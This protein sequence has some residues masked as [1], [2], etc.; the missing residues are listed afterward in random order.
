LRAPG[1]SSAREGGQ[2]SERRSAEPRVIAA[3][4]RGRGGGY[5]KRQGL[6]GSGNQGS[7]ALYLSVE[8][9]GTS[10]APVPRWSR[11]RG[12][13]VQRT[14][15]GRGAEL[16]SDEGASGRNQADGI[17]PQWCFALFPG[18]AR[19]IATGGVGWEDRRLDQPRSSVPIGHL[20]GFGTK[21]RR[22]DA[23]LIPTSRATSARSAVSRSFH[24]TG[25]GTPVI[26]RV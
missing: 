23:A 19:R 2:R 10:A 6:S 1:P 8:P 22:V 4:R 7:L 20:P 11:T 5:T 16:E 17:Q 14:G 26:S 18:P 13:P 21:P 24:V 25:A 15:R 9:R 12:F 3:S